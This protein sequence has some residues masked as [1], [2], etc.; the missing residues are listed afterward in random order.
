MFSHL[1]NTPWNKYC[2][3]KTGKSYSTEPP[4]QK[5][6][7]EESIWERIQKEKEEQKEGKRQRKGRGRSPMG[8]LLDAHFRKSDGLR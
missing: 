3:G 7:R 8:D 1:V 5:E 2:A 6:T 4:E